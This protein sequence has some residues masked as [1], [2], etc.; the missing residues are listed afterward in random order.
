MRVIAEAPT[1]DAAQSRIAEVRGI[2]DAA[3]SA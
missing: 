3:L 1:A 2:I